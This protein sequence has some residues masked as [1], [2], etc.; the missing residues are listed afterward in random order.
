ML[1]SS[2]WKRTSWVPDEFTYSTVLSACRDMKTKE[3]GD[4]IHSIILKSGFAYSDTVVGNSIIDFCLKCGCLS[5]AGESFY[6]MR[7]KDAN[8]YAIMILGLIQNGST[9]EALKLFSQMQ[10]SGVQASPVLFR[11]I[12]QCCADTS[13]VNLGKQVHSSIIKIGL[14]SDVYIEK[15]LVGLYAKSNLLQMEDC[16]RDSKSIGIFTLEGEEVDG[17][18]NYKSPLEFDQNYFMVDY[19]NCEDNEEK[20]LKF[21][22]SDQVFFVAN[23]GIMS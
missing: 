15:A 20:I 1:S 8:L 19:S 16:D 12:L 18:E 4:R 22:I 5:S 14:V 11:R 17:C 7:N 10:E 23:L 2:F 9:I 13:T 6:S 21:T 3:T